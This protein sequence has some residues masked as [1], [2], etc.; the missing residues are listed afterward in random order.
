MQRINFK[1]CRLQKVNVNILLSTLLTQ[2]ADKPARQKETNQKLNCNNIV[3][4]IAYDIVFFAFFECYIV[5]DIVYNIVYDI[6][7]DIFL[8]VWTDGSFAQP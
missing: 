2:I 6:E 7:Y 8:P 4:D 3:Y 5:Y 1:P